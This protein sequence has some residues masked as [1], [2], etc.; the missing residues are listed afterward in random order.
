MNDLSRIGSDPDAF[1]HFYR[2]HVHAVERFVARRVADPHT[3]ADLTADIFLAAVESAS[4]Y[5]SGRGSP[6]GWLYGIARN[7]VGQQA[8]G[9]ARELRAVS[10]V[11]G[12]ALL[13]DDSLRRVEERL[14]A[15]LGAREL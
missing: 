6:V 14:D 10:R 9:A 5:S 15:E 2:A 12:R 8:R 13:D 11:S 3:A 4:G 1:E 7:V